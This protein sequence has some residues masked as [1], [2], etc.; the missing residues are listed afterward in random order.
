MAT[1]IIDHNSKVATIYTEEYGQE[2]PFSKFETNDGNYVVTSKLYNNDP[3]KIV[4]PINMTTLIELGSSSSSGSGGSTGE[5][6]VIPG[7]GEGNYEVPSW[8]TV[9]PSISTELTPAT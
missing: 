2:Y 9:R 7:V 3:A 1:L 6:I 5:S 4:T 8:G